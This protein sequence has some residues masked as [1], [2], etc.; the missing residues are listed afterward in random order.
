MHPP[1]PR[2]MSASSQTALD[3][4]KPILPAEGST[5]Q[6]SPLQSAAQD[7]ED[8]GQSILM[9]NMDDRFAEKTGTGDNEADKLMAGSDDGAS[10]SDVLSESSQ[11]SLEF[12][13]AADDTRPSDCLR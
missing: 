11:L 9:R 4:S 2:I 3:A 13:R 1:N 6:S 7:H 8:R 12:D 5:A 10:D